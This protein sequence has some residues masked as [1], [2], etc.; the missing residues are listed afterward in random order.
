MLLGTGLIAACAGSPEL[1]PAHF[2]PRA[3][4]VPGWRP[5]GETQRYTRENLFDYMDGEAEMYFVYGFEEMLMQEYLGDEGGPVRVELYRVDRAENAYGLFTYYRGGQ[6]LDVGNEGDVA[7]GGR[8][9]FWKDRHFARVFSIKKVE[10]ETVQTFARRLAGELPTG[11][12]PPELVSKLPQ[13]KLLPRSEKFFHGKLALDNIIWT[14]EENVLDLGPETDAVAASY[15]Y[16]GT[17]VTLLIVAY[18]EARAAETAVRA[19]QETGCETLSAAE[20]RGR[21]LAAVFQAPDG[22]VASDLLRRTV[23]LLGASD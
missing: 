19:L 14:A 2:F 6:F 13:E 23:G 22:S 9:C 5:S 20:R 3:G 4:E 12:T 1:T 21:Y 11:G 16:G 8:L 17:E 18:S 10:E 7:L 15:D